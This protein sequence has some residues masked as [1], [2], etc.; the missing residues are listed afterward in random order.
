MSKALREVVKE[1]KSGRLDTA[2]RRLALLLS[3]LGERNDPD[4]IKLRVFAAAIAQTLSERAGQQATLYLRD[5][6]VPQI[7]LF[8]L[9][10]TKVPVVWWAR[11]VGNAMV[12]ELCRGERD[13]TLIDIGI[14]LG[15]QEVALLHRL[16]REPG[17]P[18]RMKIVAIECQ[19]GSLVEAQQALDQAAADTGIEV[20]VVKLPLSVEDLSD[21]HWAEIERMPGCKIAVS[22]F[23]LHHVRQDASGEARDLVF[24]RLARLR[25]KGL[26][27]TEPD[28]DHLTED[29]L[30]RFDQAW[31]HFGAT[32]RML[33]DLDLSEQERNALKV[34]FFG[35][36]IADI[37][38]TVRGS[39]TE[40]HESAGH[41]WRRLRQ[42]GFVP[43][44]AGGSCSLRPS[45]V[46]EAVDEG[47]H[48]SIKHRGI[49]I[50]SVLCGVP[51]EARYTAVVLSPQTLTELSHR[52]GLTA[53]PEKTA[54]SSPYALKQRPQ[55]VTRI[56]D[57]L[58]FVAQQQGARTFAVHSL[59]AS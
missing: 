47:E 48:V 57:R 38:G 49:G 3:G 36:E 44:T 51:S 16:A 28:S 39:R 17:C 58:T 23:A 14:G 21:E 33:D 37:L 9:L 24:S 19:P 18:K 10:A 20:E 27:I 30:V 42:A 1:V 41:W 7:R 56:G 31:R 40:R 50:V 6:E 35:R 22:S 54:T 29:Y 52:W 13:V 32:F 12:I 34:S 43:G 55:S 46:L 8:D 5:Y 4:A 11:Q 45:R 26:V 2:E 25:I 59:Q 53:M 15:T